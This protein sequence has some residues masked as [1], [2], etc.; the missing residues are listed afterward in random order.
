MSTDDMGIVLLLKF[1]SVSYKTA[2]H[3]FTAQ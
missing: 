3:E 1:P 2:L